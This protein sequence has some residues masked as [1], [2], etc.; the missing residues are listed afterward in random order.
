MIERAY[1]TEIDP[2]ASQRRA[3]ARHIA[4]ARAAHNWALERWYVLAGARGLCDGMRAVHG[5]DSA[6]ARAAWG[7]GLGLYGITSGE[8]T[9]TRRAA[10][11]KVKGAT[12]YQV[13]IRY[14]VEAPP[15]PVP[16]QVPHQ[17][18][19]HSMLTAEKRREDS[20][21]AWLS[22]LSAY[23][24]REGVVDLGQ[25]YQ[26]FF[27]RLGKHNRGDHSECRRKRSGA[28]ALGAP[29]FR[30]AA[31]RTWHMDQSSAIRVTATHV[32]IPGVGLVRLKEREYLPVTHERSHHFV[33]GGRACALG[34]SERGGRWYVSMRAVVPDPK[35]AKRGPGR[36]QRPRPTPRVPGLIVGVDSGVCWLSVSSLGHRFP[37]LGSD[38]LVQKL[39]RRRKLW[40]R[41]MARRWVPGRARKDQSRGWREARAQVAKY[42]RR[43]CEVRDDRVGKAVRAILD[44]GASK[45]VVRGQDIGTMLDRERASDSGTRNALA[46]GVSSA[47]MGEFARR[48]EYKGRWAGAEVVRA[49]AE[50]PSSRRCSVCGEVR[51]TDP[52][53]PDFH[54]PACGHHEDR[55]TNSARNL[56]D[57]SG[58]RPGADSGRS[59]RGKAASSEAAQ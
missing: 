1:K 8:L 37:G 52:G 17:D 20:D 44:S 46:F 47:R 54:C 13:K 50:Y 3:L 31:N 36:D 18:Q 28:C 56:R 10:R 35:P 39:L 7:L 14:R 34:L 45:I 49:A 23:A 42:H 26:N 5:L 40:E 58:L 25:G 15:G 29:K 30:N 22:E 16:D 51:D 24:V 27:R 43:I 32:K 57:Y 21:V 48:L 41:R 19:I 59:D 6:A 12:V 33:T 53:Y 9:E 11:T 38:P 2:T 4:G 55:E